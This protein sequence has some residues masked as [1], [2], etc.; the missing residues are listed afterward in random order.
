MEIQSSRVILTGAAG[1]IGRAIA[2]A[3]VEQGAR[4]VLVDINVQALQTLCSEL[5]SA[6]GEAH[7]ICADLT[8]ISG[9]DT[10]VAGA[11]SAMGGIDMLIN[12]AGLMSFRAFEDEPPRHLQDLFSVNLI[13]PIMLTRE[14]LPHMQEQDS[15]RIVNIGS[16]FGSIAF[17]YFAAYSASKFGLRGFSEALRRELA[18]TGVRVTYVAPRAVKTKLNSEE[19]LKMGEATKMKMDDPDAVAGQ[20]VDAIKGDR[21]DVYLGWPE[22]LFVRVNG[23]LPRL[24]DKAVAAQNRIARRFAKG[25]K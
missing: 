22:S 9:C 17:A 23:L 16:I 1:G 21:Q 2:F 4:L 15:G 7:P 14:V 18:D 3:L 10:V 8:E 25:E 20:I 5:R 13:A 12:N 6:G 24:V 11:I 19:V